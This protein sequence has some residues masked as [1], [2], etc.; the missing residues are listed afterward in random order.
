MIRFVDLSAAYWLDEN[1]GTT[2]PCCA[3]VSTISDTFIENNDGTHV[4]GGLYDFPDNELGRRL[5]ALV[6]EHFFDPRTQRGG[7]QR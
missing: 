1:S 7:D 3:F 6:P 2:W 4:F 5:L